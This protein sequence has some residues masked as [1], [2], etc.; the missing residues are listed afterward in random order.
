MDKIRVLVTG[1]NGLLWQK[2]VYQLIKRKDIDL[3]ATAKGP[4]R[5]IEKKGYN[6]WI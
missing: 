6:I 5:L 4:N 2:I 3:I 1:S